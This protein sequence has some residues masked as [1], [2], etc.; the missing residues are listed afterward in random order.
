M[1]LLVSGHGPF[2]VHGAQFGNHCSNG[3][4]KSRMENK[5]RFCLKTGI[6]D[7]L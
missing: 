6:R 4:S 7:G 2:G 3:Y 1:D 5:D